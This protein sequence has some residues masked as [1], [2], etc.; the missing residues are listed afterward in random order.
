MAIKLYE[1]DLS[2]KDV[3]ANPPKFSGDFKIKWHIHGY[4]SMT[5]EFATLFNGLNNNVLKKSDAD[6]VAAIKLSSK[7][8]TDSLKVAAIRREYSVNDEFFALRTDDTAIKNRIAAIIAG[9]ETERDSW[10]DVS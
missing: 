5:V 2:Q 7:K 4:V 1:W 8:E 9:I 3:L 10:L 6:G